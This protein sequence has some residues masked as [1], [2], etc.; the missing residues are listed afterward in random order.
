MGE[1]SFFKKI[2]T[3]NYITGVTKYFCFMAFLK[4]KNYEYNINA[5]LL[6]RENVGY[7]FVLESRKPAQ[8]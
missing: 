6:L 3:L 2:D 5:L 4:K 8:L 7:V 1:P